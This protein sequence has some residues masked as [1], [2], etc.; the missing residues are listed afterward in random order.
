[1][2]S[3]P[4]PAHQR[5]AFFR[6][7][8]DAVNLGVKPIPEVFQR[9]GDLIIRVFAPDCV[10]AAQIVNDIARREAAEV[11]TAKRVGRRRIRR[12]ARPQWPCD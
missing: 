9:Q 11:V 1:M 8:R 7:V 2:E 12:E 6:N 4:Q 10:A 3:Q 5:Y